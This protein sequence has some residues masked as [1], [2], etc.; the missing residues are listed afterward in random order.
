MAKFEDVTIDVKARLDVDQ[1]TAEGC[2]KLV[3]IFCNA[4]GMIIQGH[5]DEN[6][7][8]TLG[9]ERKPVLP[10]ISPEAFAA[11]NAIG[12]GSHPTDKMRKL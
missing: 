12:R 9:F 4:N 10:N 7:E 2:L 8:L 6:N 3:E 11:I 1:R 5:Y